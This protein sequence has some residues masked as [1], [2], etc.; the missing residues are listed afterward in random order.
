MLRGTDRRLIFA[1][2]EDY[3]YFLKILSKVRDETL[4]SLYT[5]CLMSNHSHL[6]AKEGNEPISDT[7]K[8]IEIMYAHHYNQ[9]YELCGHLF[10]DRFRS[11][12]VNDERAFLS[13]MRYICHNPVKAG[14]CDD[15]FLYPWLGCSGVGICA[16]DGLLDPLTGITDFSER[17]LYEFIKQESNEEHLEYTTKKF[18]SDE[19][20]VRLLC[21]ECHCKNIVE[22]GG[23]EKNRLA[24]AILTLS[25]IHI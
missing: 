17:E 4:F 10:Q 19:K 22:I 15:P 25:L 13:V 18:F 23:W 24:E 9:K 21:N 7:M 3:R 11:E 20:A 12:P 5:Y 8:R 14:L 16:G 1:D 6:L 2:D